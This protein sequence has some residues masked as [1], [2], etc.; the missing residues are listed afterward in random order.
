MK[1]NWIVTL[2]LALAML[3]MMTQAAG[4]VTLDPKKTTVDCTINGSKIEKITAKFYWPSGLASA[5]SY[6][7]V[8]NGD[9]GNGNNLFYKYEGRGDDSL[10]KSIEAVCKD[11][12]LNCIWSSAPT[13]GQPIV[14]TKYTTLTLDGGNITNDG[15]YYIYEWTEWGGRFY[16]D[17]RLG[18]LSAKNGTT[19]F[20]AGNTKAATG[21][22]TGTS[23]GN[24]TVTQPETKP[25]AEV[26][27]AAASMPKTGDES[28]PIFYAALAI[29]CCAGLMM[30]KRK[31]A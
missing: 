7:V 22:D 16:P 8:L 1:K 6:L 27:Q 19:N 20:V 4:A 13:A 25:S 12:N 31:K 28:L 14:S 17:A 30:L 3:L 5:T 29:S 11:L 10:A 9:I 21:S 18:E 2:A 23:S 15:T 24:T 26:K